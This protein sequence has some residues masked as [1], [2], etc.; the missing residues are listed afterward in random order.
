V[1]S[2]RERDA[3]TGVIS[4]GLLATRL[5]LSLLRTK[6]NVPF[7]GDKAVLHHWRNILD[8]TVAFIKS[9]TRQDIAAGTTTMS[10]RFLARAHYLTQLRSAAPAKNSKT[11]DGLSAYLR[12]IQDSILKL[13]EGR[14]ITTMQGK[15]LEAF[16]SS[17][18]QGCTQEASKL[19]QE[20]HPEWSGKP[21]LTL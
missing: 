3:I 6:K 9:P 17:I 15:I 19:Q 14:A 2:A 5:E 20:P 7:E 16:A 21:A 10:P 11:P 12:K 4:L 18:A 1:R 8:E 13:D